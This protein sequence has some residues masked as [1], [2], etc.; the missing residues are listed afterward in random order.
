MGTH[1]HVPTADERMLPEGTA[2]LT[3][4]GMT[5]PYESMI[6]MRP[7][8]VLKRF[9]LQTPAS[10]EV[11]K[12]DVRLAGGRRRHRRGDRQGAGHRAGAGEGRLAAW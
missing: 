3:D 12:R 8:P 1:T 5:G 6:G 9:L 10:F 7:G 4:V 2:L 11:A